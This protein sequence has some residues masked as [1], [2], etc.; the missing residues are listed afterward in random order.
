MLRAR[1]LL[2]SPAVALAVA[3]AAAPLLSSCAADEPTVALLVADG[4]DPS[5]RAVDVDAFTERV[6]ATCDQCRVRVYDA[7]GD[8]DTQKSQ[9]RQ[10]EARSADVVVVVP[11]EPGDLGTLTGSG[12]PVVSL[13]ELVPGS[14]RYVGLEDG[15]VPRQDGSD[16]EAARAVLLGRE[17][18]MTFVPTHAMSE[19]AADVAVA[20]LADVPAEGGEVVDGVES[21]LYRHQEVTIDSL[22]S[23]LVAQE[24]VHLDDLCSGQTE[25]RCT[26][27]GL[28]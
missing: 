3:L 2:R 7:E 21:W 28:R 8:A 4:T 22:T 15:T 6:E 27:L 25:K 10:A 5:S 9:A 1:S 16:L 19:R 17:E 20:F 12:L 24:V 11:V 18:S 23:V 26:R 13:G 14:E